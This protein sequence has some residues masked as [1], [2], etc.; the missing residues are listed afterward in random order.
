ML[1]FIKQF[2]LAPRF[3]IAFGLVIVLHVLSNYYLTFNLIADI[4]IWAL[5]ILLLGDVWIL[6][7]NRQGISAERQL[8]TR[9]SNG[10]PNPVRLQ[11]GNRYPFPVQIRLIDELPAQFQIRDFH[12]R[13][14]LTAGEK[15]TFNYKIRP[16]RRG[17]YQFGYLNV[18]VSSAIGLIEKRYQTAESAMVPVYPSFIQ[19]RKYELLAISNR[20]TEAG[21]KKIRRVGHTMEFDQIREYVKGDDYRTI[22]WKATARRNAFMVN[23]YQDERS[24]QVYSIINMGRVMK[25]PF[26]N[27]SLLD[28]AINASLV[29]SNIA[30]RKQDKAGIIT[31]SHEI[32]SILPADRK[33]AQ[34]QKI[35]EVLFRQ[36]TRFLEA[37]YDLLFSTV[38]Q[39]IRQR[40]LLLLFTNFESLNAL[41]RQLLPLRKIAKRH[42]IVLIFF[43][44]TELKTLLGA[45]ADTTETVYN[46]IIAEHFAFEKKQIVKE[47]QRYGIYSILTTPEQLSVNTINKYLYLK[48]RGFI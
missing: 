5:G 33:P 38:L 13:Q 14:H 34:M 12:L 29:I 16:T 43:E 26:D 28:Y 23:H 35:Q 41:K 19:M 22:N 3:Y 48:A 31:F 6:F 15:A 11:V 4:S 39:K 20:L 2:F 1:T 45:P 36:E 42:L 8:P 27:M 17:A 25:M 21:V 46:K 10:D 32:N 24:Q 30:V 18:F 44:N 40:S 37:N 7:S 47:L 9:F